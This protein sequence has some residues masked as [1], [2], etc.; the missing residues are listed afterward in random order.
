M[1]GF[2]FLSRSLCLRVWVDDVVC[3]FFFFFF[4]LKR[5]SSGL[6]GHHTPPHLLLFFLFFFPPLCFV[7][8]VL[9]VR[10]FLF[11]AFLRGAILGPVRFLD[12]LGTALR[13]FFGRE[14]V[15]AFVPFLSVVFPV[16]R[17]TRF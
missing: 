3:C 8:P 16:L 2:P 11:L 13:P 14:A 4:F 17:L 15:E 6:T 12:S 5:Q 10:P 9:A 1:S 7:S